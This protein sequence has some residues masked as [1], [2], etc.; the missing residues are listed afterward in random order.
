MAHNATQAEPEIEDAAEETALAQIISRPPRSL[1]HDAWQRLIANKAAVP[2]RIVI[3]FFVFVAI[4]APLIAPHNPLR[5][6][7]RQRVFAT[8]VGGSIGD[9]QGG[10]SR[11]SCL[12]PTT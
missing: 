12:A 4:F 9:G 10:R 8:G 11:I 2:A 5:T 6:E 1:W 7:Q 3:L